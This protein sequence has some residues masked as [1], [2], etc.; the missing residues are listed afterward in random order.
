MTAIPDEEFIEQDKLFDPALRAK[1][2]AAKKRRDQHL[3]LP[4]GLIIPPKIK[5]PSEAK[6]MLG[7][8][9]CEWRHRKHNFLCPLKLNKKDERF[10]VN[11][12]CLERK[13]YLQSF[14][15]TYEKQPTWHRWHKDYMVNR[16]GFRERKEYVEL[17]NLEHDLNVL[18]DVT[19]SETDDF[20]AWQTKL[21]FK[22]NEFDKAYGRWQ[23]LWKDV[24][25]F[26]DKQVDRE[27]VKQV[28][29]QV[30]KHT[31]PHGQILD[32]MRGDYTVEEETKDK[33]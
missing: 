18:R 29:M 2:I 13:Q 25:S 16:A 12:I 4:L 26:E 21:R 33:E 5:I 27:T 19:L 22:Q 3:D 28:D 10:H 14:T 24:V 9:G 31:I 8:R 11:G 20:K 15:N 7:C 32:I 23:S 30:T 17:E 6:R 1:A